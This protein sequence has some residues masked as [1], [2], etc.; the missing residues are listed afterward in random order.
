M[1]ARSEEATRKAAYINE[2]VGENARTIRVGQGL[3]QAQVSELLGSMC[4]SYYRGIE[5]GL[6]QISL[7]RLV[8]IADVLGVHPGELLEG[9]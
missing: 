3:T 9:V 2:V 5:A 7:V 6:K 8:D 1:K 4:E